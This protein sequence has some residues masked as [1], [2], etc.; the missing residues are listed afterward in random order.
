MWMMTTS[1]S[2]GNQRD[3][4]ASRLAIIASSDADLYPP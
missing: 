4:A 2:A 1:T 3:F